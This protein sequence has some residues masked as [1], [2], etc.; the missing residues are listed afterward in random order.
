MKTLKLEPEHKLTIE[1]LACYLPYGLKGESNINYGDKYQTIKSDLL[2]INTD[3]LIVQCYDIYGK[4]WDK[5][6]AIKP[7]DFKP[8]LLPL[9]E[10]TDE[11]AE[12]FGYK[13]SKWYLLSIIKNQQLPYVN[14]VELLK[15][16]YDVYSLIDKGLAISKV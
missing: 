4:K 12:K 5:T 8:L 15:L 16:H 10:L 7:I 11:L 9:S 14:F 13:N 3:I 1:N 6:I 2:G